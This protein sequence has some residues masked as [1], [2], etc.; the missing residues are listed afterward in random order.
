[1]GEY[2]DSQKLEQKWF[3]WLLGEATPSLDDLR[4]KGLLW[5]KVIGK[6]EFKGE[7]VTKRG[8]TFPDAYH[9]HRLHCIALG[10]PQFFESHDGVPTPCANPIN[11][12]VLSLDDV[13]KELNLQSSSF[14]HNL[15]N[16]LAVRNKVVPSLILDGYQLE[17]PTL[18]NWELMLS[19]INNI[20]LGI[21]Q[22]FHP[23]TQEDLHDLANEAILTICK[24]LK[25]QKLAYVAGV[26]PVFNLLTTAIF[27]VMYSICNKKKQIRNGSKKLIDDAA[28]GILPREYRSYT[29]VVGSKKNARLASKH[30]RE[31]AYQNESNRN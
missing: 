13:R 9:P 22:K 7:I 26:A 10:V 16:P 11:K 28:A 29:L 31:L 4:N 25:S 12:S 20:C 14:I 17:S 2:C 23:P 3:Q 5:T 24:K 15:D 19:D 6:T 27:R 30:R 18:Q 8:R 1:V 21:A